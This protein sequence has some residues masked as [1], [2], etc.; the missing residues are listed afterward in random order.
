MACRWRRSAGRED[1]PGNL[2]QLA[3]EVCGLSPDER[4]RLK[5]LEE[6]NSRFGVL[7]ISRDRSARVETQL[8]VHQ[9]IA[10]AMQTA[11]RKMSARLS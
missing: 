2:F 4:R 10:A 7:P 3:Q 11:D 6:E 5:A 8:S 1:K 9:V